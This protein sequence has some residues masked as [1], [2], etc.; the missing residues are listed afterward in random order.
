M[1]ITLIGTFVRIIS[2][3]NTF[4]LINYEFSVSA[5]SSWVYRQSIGKLLTTR[6]TIKE[7]EQ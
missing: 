3:L 1:V 4:P 7:E 6:A 5:K 2:A